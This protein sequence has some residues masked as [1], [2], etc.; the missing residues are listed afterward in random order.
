MMDCIPPWRASHASWTSLQDEALGTHDV[1]AVIHC[2]EVQHEQCVRW[3][4][5]SH[6][7]L[8]PSALEAESCPRP[9]PSVALQG[10]GKCWRGRDV[11]QEG[12]AASV[13]RDK[14]ALTFAG[15]WRG[16]VEEDLQ[17][18]AEGFGDDE[19]RRG[20]EQP[21]SLWKCEV[22]EKE[23]YKTGERDNLRPLS[24]EVCI[25]AKPWSMRSFLLTSKRKLTLPVLPA[26][27]SCSLVHIL[28]KLTLCGWCNLVWARAGLS[29][30]GTEGHLCLLAQSSVH[31][32]ALMVHAFPVCPRCFCSGAVV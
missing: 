12:R 6:S 16:W 13:G 20:Y 30:E 29:Q 2:F 15:V 14:Q 18:V 22:S 31:W 4:H 25:C 21:F 7:P 26:L 32:E 24:V 17:R 3:W 28:T 19:Q 1:D 23:G 9:F 10:A 27:P 8:C 5:Y 11:G